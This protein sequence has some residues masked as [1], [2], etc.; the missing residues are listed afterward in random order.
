M[1]Y[2]DIKT[3]LESSPDIKRQE[4]VLG[5]ECAA[6]VLR[7]GK[8]TRLE[9]FETRAVAGGGIA[10]VKQAEPSVGLRLKVGWKTRNTCGKTMQ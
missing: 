2:I 7:P 4:N 1:L 6:M 10:S 8:P 9:S 5:R 3:G